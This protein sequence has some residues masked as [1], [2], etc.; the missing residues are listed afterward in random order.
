MRFRVLLSC[1]QEPTVCR[2]P[3]PDE[4]SPNFIPI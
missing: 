1:S 3:E 4:S 2:N